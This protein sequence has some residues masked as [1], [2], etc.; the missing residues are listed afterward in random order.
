MSTRKPIDDKTLK[1]IATQLMNRGIGELHTKGLTEQ[2]ESNHIH[3]TFCEISKLG[4][5]H[6]QTLEVIPSDGR[7]SYFVHRDNSR[8]D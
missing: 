3:K 2:E 5:D 4:Y 1:Q 8:L 7:K 6:I